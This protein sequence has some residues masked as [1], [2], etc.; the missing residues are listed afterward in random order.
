MSNVHIRFLKTQSTNSQGEE[1]WAKCLLK[2]VVQLCCTSTIILWST[3]CKRMLCAHQNA[4]NY[5]P[6][7]SCTCLAHPQLKT[8][9]SQSNFHHQQSLSSFFSK[10]GKLVYCNDVEGLLQ[11]LAC[12]HNH[13][14][15]RLFVDLSKFS[16]KALLLTY[17]HTPWSRILL[18]KLTSSQLVKKSPAFYGT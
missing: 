12:T 13:E 6:A 11:E 8:V 18:E 4:V 9:I 2:P 7:D 15:W 10:D 14:E 5:F 1:I 3:N 16:S 17:L